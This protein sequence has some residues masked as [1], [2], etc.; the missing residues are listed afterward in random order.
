[1]PGGVNHK[2]IPPKICVVCDKPFTWRKKW[3]KCWDEVQT[4][5][6]RCKNE[7]KRMALAAKQEAKKEGGGEGT[8]TAAPSSE[9]QKDATKDKTKIAKTNQDRDASPLALP[10]SAIP[11]TPPNPE[12]PEENPPTPR[13]LDEAIGEIMGGVKNLSALNRAS[14]ASPATT[15]ASPADRPFQSPNGTAYR[16]AV[17]SMCP[18]RMKAAAREEAHRKKTKQRDRARGANRNR[19]GVGVWNEAG[20]DEGVVGLYDGVAEDGRFE[21]EVEEEESEEEG[22]EGTLEMVVEEEEEEESEEEEERGRKKK[23]KKGGKEGKR[24]QDKVKGGRGRGAASKG[25]TAKGRRARSSSPSSS[26]ASEDEHHD[27]DNVFPSLPLLRLDSDGPPPVLP[28]G[29]QGLDEEHSGGTP[30]TSA[31][32]RVRTGSGSLHLSSKELKKAEK[33]QAREARREARREKKQG[34]AG[35]EEGEV[36]VEGDKAAKWR[37][38]AAVV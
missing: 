10:A 28:E 19:K 12:N 8:T 26:S 11:T 5:S 36:E 21:S 29:L 25:K 38:T 7:R 30:S 17:N 37:V 16:A 14:F 34:A 3:E 2:N 9:T 1:M 6:E 4:C 22:E 32:T 23:D 24:H 15:A 35:K 33:K 27:D 20:G 13:S 18:G 31:A